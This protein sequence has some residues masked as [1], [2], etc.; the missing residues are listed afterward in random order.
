MRIKAVIQGVTQT[1]LVIAVGFVSIF[2]INMLS[3]LIEQ[4]PGT[5]F[6]SVIQ[7]TSR[8]WLNAHFV[9][10]QIA[11]GKV[12][13]VKVPAYE[14]TLVPLGFSALI[15]YFMY[16]AG[17]QIASQEH[18][19]FAWLGSISS[20]GLVAFAATSVSSSKEI[21]VLDVAGVFLP[22]IIFSLVLVF[23]SLYCA[24]DEEGNLRI[25]IRDFFADRASK[26]PWAIK[27]VIQPAL[28][29]GSAVVLALAAV[30]SIATA[31]LI[32]FNWVDAIKLYQGLQLSF[33]GTLVISFGQLAVLPNL[34]TYGMSW[35]TGVGFSLGVGSSVS[36]LA[37]EL[38][39]LPAIPMLTALPSGTDSLMIAFVLVTLLSAFAATI[40]VKP[41]TAQ[42]RFDYAST[43][44]AALALGIGI[45]LVAAL[46][47][48][49]LALLSS[50]SI[51]P[52][53]MSQIG[54]NPWLVFLVTFVEVTMMSCLAAFFSARTE[55]VDTE[56][57]SRVKRLK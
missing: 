11:E 49:V 52:E 4:N 32:A 42:L 39:P 33:I 17:K 38:G 15:I 19:G 37:N 50:G 3:W 21:K 53:R 28:R 16:R 9:A 41:Y 31:L 43:T 29:A 26:M 57:L 14:F 30:S 35:F 34:I 12:A 5:T 40:L 54:I 55:G 56:L 1:S 10:I 24:S 48:L 8:I 7:T 46:E 22:L 25:K 51:G 2:F 47:M 23:S 27:P 18:L 13:G 45:G 6:N 36:P 44:G 20:Y